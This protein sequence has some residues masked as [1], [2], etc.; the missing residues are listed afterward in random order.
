MMKKTVLICLVFFG[1]TLMSSA[2]V[3]T[4]QFEYTA[5]TTLDSNGWSAHSGSFNPISVGASSLTL[6]QYSPT[7]IGGSAISA[8]TSQDVNKSF[9]EITSGDVFASFLL[10]VDTINSSGYFFHLMEDVLPS[11]NFRARTFFRQ[12]ANNSNAFNLGLTFSSSSGVY[13][14]TEFTYGSTILVV[15]KYSIVSG[16]NND[17]VRLY[18]FDASGT[19]TTEPSSPLLGPITATGTQS[20][21]DPARIALRQFGS[22]AGYTVDAFSISTSWNMTP[23]FSQS[24]ID[25]PI[26]WDDNTVDYTVTDFGGNASTS[27]V[28]PTNAANTVLQSTKSNTAQ[29]WA[30]TTLSVDSSGLATAIPFAVGSTS[31]SVAVWSPDANIPIRLKAE[32]KTDPTKSVETEAMV[33]TASV[34]DTLV[35]DFSNQAAGTAAINFSYTYDKLSIFYNFGTDG[36]TAGTKTYYCDDVYFGAAAPPTPGLAIIDLPITWD[37]TANVDYTVTDFG[38]NAST[39]VVDPTNAANTVLQSTKSNTA[40]LWA[41]TTLSVDSSGLA[42]A[43]PFA[44]GSTSIS[45][46]V[47]SPDANIPIR[48][49][50][51]DKTDPTKSVETEAMVMTASV[52][53][54]L[55]FDFS[56]QAA[57]TAAINF[58]YTYDKLSIFYNFGTDGATAG[59][60]TYYC[61]DVYFGS[62]TPPALAQID[63][64]ITWDDGTNVDYTV[65]DFGGDSSAVV[66]DPTNASNMVLMST[67]T[68]GAQTWAGTTLSTPSGLATAIPFAAGST[69]ISVAVWSPDAGTVVRLKAEDHTDPTKSVETEVTTGAA[70]TW[71]TL[72]FDFSNQVAGTAAIDFTY[73]YDLV[74]IF[75]DFLG[76]P[77]TPAKT[78]YCD[79]VYFGSQTIG[80]EENWVHDFKVYP[81]PNNGEFTI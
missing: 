73:T 52:W 57:G 16:T 30:G 47:W 78:Y 34:W 58:S 64:P 72:V 13:D 23:V 59:T 50:A 27:V 51:E 74:S 31:I 68:S 71:D 2:Q 1:I 38:G 76:N 80:I 45:V 9:G 75:Y 56:N 18:A 7:S 4:E 19:F 40:Q 8:G 6:T 70:A 36:A 25:L 5:G 35:F 81:N 28:D 39:S 60:K 49:K 15:V 77:S 3:F 44:V 33:M 46:A 54:T 21:I 37:D 14:T 43:I 69:T 41:G 12:D 62:G 11:F 48:L 20:D 63:L 79:D 26:T 32:D 10:K 42:T 55:V 53:D 24:Q 22:N 66:I 29:L 65:T 61:D 17:E 67:K